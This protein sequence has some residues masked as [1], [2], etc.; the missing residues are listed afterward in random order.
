MKYLLKD[1]G[2][3]IADLVVSL[4]LI[5]I[6][7]SISYK[8]LFNHMKDLSVSKGYV[9]QQEVS[10]F[11]EKFFRRDIQCTKTLQKAEKT[12]GNIGRDF[13]INELVS[14]RSDGTE[15]TALFFSGLKK[16]LAGSGGVDVSFFP[17][18]HNRELARFD[19]TISQTDKDTG[20]LEEKKKTFQV[21]ILRN[22]KGEIERCLNSSQA[23]EYCPGG[24]HH[25]LS[26]DESSLNPITSNPIEENEPHGTVYKTLSINKFDSA[27]GVNCLS[28]TSCDQ[29]EWINSTYCYNSCTDEV[30]SSEEDSYRDID[31]ENCAEGKKVLDQLVRC[32]ERKK[33]LC[34][35]QAFT[36]PP[37]GID[38]SEYCVHNRKCLNPP[39]SPNSYEY[40]PPWIKSICVSGSQRFNYPSS[41][42]SLPEGN[43]GEATPF[44]RAIKRKNKD[45]LA[46]GYISVYARCEYSGEWRVMG[47]TCDESPKMRPGGIPKNVWGRKKQSG[48]CWAKYPSDRFSCD[49]KKKVT[50]HPNV[51]VDSYGKPI[52]PETISIKKVY[53]DQ[54]SDR[55]DHG[56]PLRFV[57]DFK[58]RNSVSY[59][60]A[61]DSKT[62]KFEVLN[63]SKYCA[64]KDRRPELDMI[65]VIDNSG[66]MKQE[67]HNLAT[68]L[69]RF[70]DQFLSDK[71]SFHIT[72]TTTDSKDRVGGFLC[73][74]KNCAGQNVSVSDTKTRLKNAIRAGT[75]GSGTE[76]SFQP[77]VDLKQRQADFFRPKSTLAFFFLT[78][79]DDQSS[80]TVDQFID[81]L[82]S[83]T[84]IGSVI[85][86]NRKARKNTIV[87]TGLNDS[88]SAAQYGNP[89]HCANGADPP[90][91]RS[92]MAGF[93]AV[94]VSDPSL[95][96]SPNEVDLCDPYFSDRLQNFGASLASLLQVTEPPQRPDSLNILD[97]S[98]LP[99]DLKTSTGQ[100]NIDC[101]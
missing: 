63:Q 101:P 97:K 42:F 34:K 76:K 38:V 75:G 80:F 98:S 14:V 69:D 99:E 96:K 26:Y 57:F 81:F 20:Q 77:I 73:N 94:S 36:L 2:F 90:K 62:G 58:G 15:Q 49:T 17:I 55:V 56:A 100:I 10:H 66:S 51:K 5:S 74:Y 72:V 8:Y 61:C 41:S 78:D 60:V 43:Y 88:T 23:V 39:C 52:N 33:A 64:H 31:V 71:I 84:A 32:K 59:T 89:P 85:G 24:A 54:I 22:K 48:V 93:E 37:C 4:F 35:R 30:W 50:L 18:K 68:N 19:Y 28:Y 44:R 95:Y 6:V 83:S 1:K 40:D 9:D 47:A 12:S 27:T 70:L 91:I 21:E 79:E 86:I 11:I 87:F 53:N 67:Q 25:I 16:K 92:F 65:F 3:S 82:F 29:G 45:S 46:F 7:T 13:S